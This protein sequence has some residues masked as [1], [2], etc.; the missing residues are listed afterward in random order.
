M[1]NLGTGRIT[2]S[3]VIGHEQGMMTF[4]L[5]GPLYGGLTGKSDRKN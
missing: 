4:G 1:Y 2:T 5:S 3:G